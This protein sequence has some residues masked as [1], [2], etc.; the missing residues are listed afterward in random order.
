MSVFFDEVETIVSQGTS[1]T[2]PWIQNKILEFQYSTSTPYLLE[3][4]DNIM[5]YPSIVNADK[6]ISNCAV[7]VSGVGNLTIKVTSGNPAIPLNSSQLVALNSYLTNFL[8]PNQQKKIIS[9]AADKLAIYGTV[10]YNGQLNSSIQ[11]SVIAAL[12]NYITKFSTSQTSGGSFN[13][14]VKSS[15]IAKIIEGVLGVVDWQPAQITATPIVGTSTNLMIGSTIYKR[16]YAAYSGYIENDGSN[17][18]STTLIFVPAN[19]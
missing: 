2:A 3:M 7:T 5:T 13:G 1:Q 8:N 10:Y 17:P 16:S 15:D 12:N 4:I 18:F 19:N 6:I 14:L 11:G 9:V